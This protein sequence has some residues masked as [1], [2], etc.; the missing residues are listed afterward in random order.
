MRIEGNYP[1]LVYFIIGLFVV[2]A[3]AKT[4]IPI[5]PYK[6]ILALI[7]ALTMPSFIPGHGEVIM[8][9]PTGAVF[10]VASTEFKVIGAILTIINYFIAWFILYKVI[11]LFKGS[12]NA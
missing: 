9:I 12:R 10:N 4:N 1:F 7:V 3:L 5:K 6:I 2:L 11:G 8:V